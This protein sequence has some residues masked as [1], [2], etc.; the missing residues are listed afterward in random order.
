MGY[1]NINEDAARYKLTEAEEQYNDSVKAVLRCLPPELRNDIAASNRYAGGIFVVNGFTALGLMV[2]GMKM[3]KHKLSNACWME[4]ENGDNPGI[5]VR[6]GAFNWM[7]EYNQLAVLADEDDRSYEFALTDKGK[8]TYAE[9]VRFL[10]AKTAMAEP[11]PEPEEKPEEKPEEAA[12]AL[13]PM[14][15]E[16][17]RQ[18]LSTDPRMQG[19]AVHQDGDSYVLRV[20]YADLGVLVKA[21]RLLGITKVNLTPSE[22]TEKAAPTDGRLACHHCGGPT[23]NS[24]KSVYIKN[25]YCSKRECCNARQREYTAAKRKLAAKERK[26]AEAAKAPWKK[27]K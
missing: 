9:K 2:M 15:M 12:K 6:V 21:A 23:V 5:S 1:A 18:E 16:T 4:W 3:K 7:T 25:H 14:E 13:S 27:K 19:H 24:G 20:K 11:K 10:S 17:A 8:S 22:E 26:A